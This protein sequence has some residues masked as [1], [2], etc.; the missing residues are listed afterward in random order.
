MKKLLPILLLLFIATTV[1]ATQ[2]R[3]VLIIGIDG[4]RSD[5]LIKANTPV[6]DSIV[7]NGTYTF[8]A[9]HMGITVSGPSW[10]TVMT[11]VWDKKHNVT[12]NDY[13]GSK[14]NNFP[15]FTTRAKELKPDLYCVQVVEWPPLNDKVYNDSWNKKIQTACDACQDSRNNTSELGCEE[16]A[17][18]NL[19]CMFIY[20]DQVDIAGHSSGFNP[21]NPAYIAAIEYVDTRLRKLMDCL[22]ARPT[23]EE[24][25]WLV[26]LVPD[27]GGIGT[28]H[29]GGT[30]EER[31][32]WWIASGNSVPKQEINAPDPGTYNALHVLLNGVEV[33][34][35]EKLKNAPV[36]SDIA[37]TALHHLLAD[38]IKDSIDK[39]ISLWKL[40][41]KSWLTKFTT[42][43]AVIDQ[44]VQEFNLKIY[45]NPVQDMLTI[46]VDY[47][48]NSAYK[49]SIIDMSGKEVKSAQVNASYKLQVD[50]SQMPTGT[51]IVRIDL[52]DG[53][54]AVQPFIKQ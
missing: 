47:Q 16:L 8:T 40:D 34:N 49:Y 35:P 43:T 32:I 13:T 22:R 12:N 3:K 30:K 44:D 28:G 20:F 4:V 2:K 27:H 48:Q 50:C 42:P 14:F 5:A 15:Y 19:D 29:G 11:G 26:L 36:Q 25:D 41:G 38:Q 54:S 45:P 6:I 7:A 51:Y 24:E 1:S 33:A 37:V 39:Y 52:P 18:E 10:S 9:Y 46:W 23:Y 21:N 31:Q 17:N 53:K